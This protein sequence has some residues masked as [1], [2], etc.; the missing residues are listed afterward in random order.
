MSNPKLQANDPAWS[1]VSQA[2]SSTLR[3]TSRCGYSVAV[4]AS[5][6]APV[7]ANV[8]VSKAELWPANHKMV[9]VVVSYLLTDSCPVTRSLSVSSNE[10]LNGTGDGDATPDWEVLDA[11]R[12]RLRAE[13]AGTGSGREYTITI[14]ATDAGSAT[15]TAT[16]IVRVPRN[17]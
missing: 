10:P 11:N 6:P 12:I 9:D 8:A 3:T 13:R 17:R 16:T 15:S 4:V 5:N 2:C 7:I 14:T 1:G